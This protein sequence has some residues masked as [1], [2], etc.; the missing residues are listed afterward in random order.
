MCAEGRIRRVVAIPDRS[1]ENAMRQR[2]TALALVTALAIPAVPAVASAYCIHNQTPVPIDIRATPQGGETHSFSIP[3]WTQGSTAPVDCGDASQG[4]LVTV[5]IDAER[6]TCVLDTT[7][8]GRVY[9]DTVNRQKLGV[10]ADFV[11]KSVNNQH[12]PFAQ[13]YTR[14]PGYA[15]SVQFLATADIQY[16]QGDEEC[17]P[18]AD[19]TGSVLTN[20][21]Y[22]ASFNGTSG[23]RGVIVAGD[24]SMD[25]PFSSTPTPSCW[26]WDF[27]CFED[28][29]D[30]MAQ[31]DNGIDSYEEYQDHYLPGMHRFLYDGLGNHDINPDGTSLIR[32]WQADH[33]RPTRTTKWGEPHYS[34]DWDDVHFVQLNL[35]PGTDANAGCRHEPM[36]SLQYLQNDLREWVGKSGRPVVLVFHYTVQDTVAPSSCGLGWTAYDQMLF[37]D[38]IADYNVVAI[39]NG[40]DHVAPHGAWQ[41]TFHEPAGGQTR[42]D[43]RTSLPTF[44]VGAA[45]GSAETCGESGSFVEVTMNDTSMILKRKKVLAGSCA[46]SDVETVT[47][48]LPGTMYESAC[49]IAADEYGIVAGQT[50]GAAPAHVQTYWTGN[51][52]Q[53]STAKDLCQLLSDK[54]GITAGQ[55]WGFAPPDVQDL[56]IA[57]GCQTAA[58][59][60]PCQIASDEHGIRHGITWGIAPT[61]V[62]QWWT[63]QQC[64]T[65]T[66]KSACQAA[67]DKYGMK[68]GYTYGFAPSDI[69]L[70]WN[71]AGCDTFPTF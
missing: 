33:R 71:G 17:D 55:D 66:T 37:W 19:C 29:L 6:F 68:A 61:S 18:S 70:W 9:L 63:A 38:A 26:P 28:Y 51:G 15:R 47:L 43:G 36:N 42:R 62:Q 13:S 57:E 3:G 34:W 24:M 32:D 10:P 22:S 67:S 20:W 8:Y 48:D 1:K 49:Q 53:A 23:Y 25:A 65:T 39:L 58:S 50:W 16:N 11:C 2:P 7:G 40:H 59:N 12:Q 44:V 27:G 30:D 45:R 41:I 54:Y 14:G 69:M 21:M 46:V 5:E 60:S 35:Y 64:T 52:C 31:H 4:D 56:W